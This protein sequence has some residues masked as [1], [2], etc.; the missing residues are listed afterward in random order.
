MVNAVG[1]FFLQLLASTAVK[2]RHFYIGKLAYLQIYTVT[3]LYMKNVF[4]NYIFTLLRK[5]CIKTIM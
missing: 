2:M 1:A 5:E 4:C 3:E